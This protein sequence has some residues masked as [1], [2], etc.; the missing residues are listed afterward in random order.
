MPTQTEIEYLNLIDRHKS[1]I[2]HVC[3]VY[4]YGDSFYAAELRQEVL[5]AL[6]YEYSRFG[7]SRFRKQCSESTWVYRISMNTAISYLR[8]SKRDKGVEL[9][10]QELLNE[11][12]GESDKELKEELYNILGNLN[13]KDRRLMFYYL[14]ERPYV[15]IAAM[16]GMSESAVGTRVSRLL[17]KLK[18]MYGKGLHILFWL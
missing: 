5:C 4:S 15:E 18:E 12:V 17:K 14:E 1:V 16:E 13:S 6:W 10:S 7:L 8:K 11:V 2:Y 9:V 3:E